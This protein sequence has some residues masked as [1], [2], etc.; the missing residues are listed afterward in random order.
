MSSKTDKSLNGDWNRPISL[1]IMNLKK[2]LRFYLHLNEMS[3]SQLAKKSGVPKQSLSGWLS[4][5]TPRDV[6]QIKRVAD[7]F[8]TSVDNL[9][10]GDGKTID[11][12]IQ[13]HYSDEMGISDGITLYDSVW[14]DR[15]YF[16]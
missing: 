15:I 4:G 9:L 6:R 16:D 12:K 2:Q 1:K 5:N 10:F 8:C 11:A 3:A 7:V 14:L 13:C